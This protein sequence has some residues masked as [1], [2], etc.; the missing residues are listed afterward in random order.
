MARRVLP[1][2]PGQTARAKEFEQLVLFAL[3]PHEAG[4]LGGKVV[5]PG[6]ER[7]QGRKLR[8]QTRRNDLEE[9]LR[10]LQVLEA[11]IAEIVEAYVVRQGS[12]CKCSSGVRD[13][14]LSAVAGACNPSYAM[15]VEPHVIPIQKSSFAAVDAHPHVHGC[16]VRPGMCRQSALTFECRSYGRW[17]VMK[18]EEE[19]VPLSGDLDARRSERLAEEAMMVREEFRI[20]IAQRLKQTR[21]AFDVGHQERDR[22]GRQDRGWR[23]SGPI[24]R[25]GHQAS[26][27]AMMSPLRRRGMRRP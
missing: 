12:L 9:M 26:V 1:V 14:D 13:N 27:P 4:D 6:S 25:I 8:L 7:S 3:A 11:V 22:S 5:W 17:C 2:P 18:D 21:G 15:D 24:D 23:N 10:A 16:V 19:S 20:A